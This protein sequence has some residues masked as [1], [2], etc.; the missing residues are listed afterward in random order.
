MELVQ[1]FS[2]ER[3][4]GGGD[5]GHH[6]GQ[7]SL[8]AVSAPSAL[9]TLSAPPGSCYYC[10]PSL[11]CATSCCQMKHGCVNVSSK[12]LTPHCD[13]GHRPEIRFVKCHLE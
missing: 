13:A 1:R 9:P 10:K 11:T 8:S 6:S 2:T 12:A 3:G 5:G 4:V 7:S